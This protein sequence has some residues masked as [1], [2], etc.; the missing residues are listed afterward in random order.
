MNTLA[1]IPFIPEWMD[2][3]ISAEK[4]AQ[5]NTI[6]EQRRQRRAARLPDYVT[7]YESRALSPL[8]LWEIQNDVAAYNATLTTGSGGLSPVGTVPGGNTTLIVGGLLLAG[9]ALWFFTRRK[10]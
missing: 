4:S 9:A 6:R 2:P 1:R 3:T 7:E 10:R 8:Q 5:L